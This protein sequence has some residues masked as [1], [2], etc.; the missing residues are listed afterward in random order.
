MT[1]KQLSMKDL[2]EKVTNDI[3]E[4]GGFRN[5]IT[6][7]GAPDLEEYMED[8]ETEEDRSRFKKLVQR[9]V[10]NDVFPTNKKAVLDKP[11][12][13][14]I[15]AKNSIRVEPQCKIC[16]SKF[17]TVYMEWIT[18][19]NKS[20]TECSALAK[21]VFGENISPRTFTNHSKNHMMNKNLI[22][23]AMVRQDPDVD[24]IRE[25]T[26]LLQLTMDEI[27][28][29]E[30]INVKKAKFAK[31]LIKVLEDAKAK[32]AKTATNVGGDLNVTQ[33]NID[34]GLP[35]STSSKDT[36][37]KILTDEE[38]EQLEELSEIFKGR[39]TNAIRN[40]IP[41]KPHEVHK[42]STEIKDVIF[43]E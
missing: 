40:R 16:T 13:N 33:I 6:I 12:R 34:Q 5:S 14:K 10:L 25:G 2:R 19:D 28:I 11:L 43:E 24:P 22:R 7:P 23:K 36:S 39:G 1:S 21:I 42:E 30:R 3:D 38:R 41:K 20:M 4:D 27:V 32:R 17:Y 8:L 35:K 37:R 18:I 26:A 29:D 31:D 15:I 9:K